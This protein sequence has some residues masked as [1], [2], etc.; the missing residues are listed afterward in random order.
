MLLRGLRQC[1]QEHRAY[2]G[3]SSEALGN[4]NKGIELIVEAL[5]R[6]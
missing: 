1:Q 4:V 6:P 2:C 3:S 5:A